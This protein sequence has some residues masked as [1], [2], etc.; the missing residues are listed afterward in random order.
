MSL[1]FSILKEQKFNLTVSEIDLLSLSTSL[2]L[3]ICFCFF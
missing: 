2:Q 1:V 3:Y